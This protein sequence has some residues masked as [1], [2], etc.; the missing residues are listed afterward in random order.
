K[1]TG[2]ALDREATKATG[3]PVIKDCERCNGNGFS[4]MPSTVAYG[5]ITA[6]LPELT[7]SS[8][9]RNWKP[10]YEALVAKCDVEEGRAAE[11]FQKITK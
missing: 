3:A 1:G 2:K 7:Q 11:E 5:A 4:R 9:S 8:W 10:F 6:L